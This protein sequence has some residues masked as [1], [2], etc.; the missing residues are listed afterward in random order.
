M[1]NIKLNS[2]VS[3]DNKYGI[4]KVVDIDDEKY[5]VS[6]FIDI[7]TQVKQNFNITELE[8]VYLSPQTRVYLKDDSGQWKI[9][10][11]KD[12]DN[13]T[14]PEMDYL[15][16]FP[17]HKE[18]WYAS[19]EL[20]VRCLL[21]TIDPTEVLST[22]G[23]ESQFLYDSRKNVQK[24][25]I[26]LRA[27]SRGITALTSASIDLVVHQVNI[28]RKILTDPIQRYLLSD[29]VGMG[30]TIEAGII[31][32]Q[33]LL[34][35]QYSKVLIIVPSH[36]LSKWKREMKER[37][38]FD[39]FEDRFEIT[40][41]EN[42]GVNIT[43]P[44]LVIVDEAHHLLGNLNT[45]SESIRNNIITIATKSAKLLLLSATPGIGNE[46]V[47][48]NLLKVLDPVVFG[49]ESLDVFKEK[50]LKQTEHG[51]F[52]RTLKV[53][54]STFLLKRNLPKIED[55]FPG[56]NQ[57]KILKDKI[58]DIID[59]EYKEE[60]RH[61]LIKQLRI[62]L[63]ETWRLHNRLIRTRRVD[64]EGWEFQE[65]GKKENNSYV[66]DNIHSFEHPNKIVEQINSQ[67]EEW[68]SYLSLK[69]LDDDK[70]LSLA[71]ERYIALL[72]TSNM[73]FD[74]FKK[75]IDEYINTPLV[76]EELEYLRNILISIDD[77]NYA[78]N[79]SKIC[80]EIQ[81]FLNNINNSSIGVL[82]IS[83]AILAKRYALSLQS[84]FDEESVCLLQSVTTDSSE[85]SDSKLRIIVCDRNS[86][87]GVD[88]QF[89]DAIIHLDLPLNPSRVEQ[90]IGRLDRYGRTKSLKIQHLIMIPTNDESYP[91]LAWYKLLLNG[92]NIFHEPIS[93]IQLKL[94]S[95]T[96][97]LQTMLFAHGTLGLESNFD[98][99]ENITGSLIDKI[100]SVI[101]IER[102]ALDEQYALNHLSLM[103]SESFNI[104]DEIEEVEYDERSLEEDMNHWLFSVLQFYKWNIND[105]IFEIKWHPKTLI[106]K[107]Q[108]W[109]NNTLVS[110]SM[111]EGEFESSLDR[112]LTYY[113]KDAV[114]NKE[115]SLLRPGHPLFTTL[116]HYMDWEDRGTAFSTFRVVDEKFPIF[117]PRN[118]IKI[119]FKLHFIVEAGF[120]TD[121][122]EQE[123]NSE[124]FLY[125]RRVDDYHPPKI[126]TVY[127]DENLNVIDDIDITDVLDEPY[128]DL[129]NIDTNL[130][131]RRN[132]IDYF[133]DS[134]ILDQLCLDVSTRSKEILL[135]SSEYTSFNTEAVEKARMDIGLKCVSLEHR[136][137][138]QAQLNNQ[139]MSEEYD[140]TIQ[141]E[142]SLM[143]GITNP[144]IK[145]DSFGMY[146]LSRFP[147]SELNIDD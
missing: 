137:N 109:S 20:E 120:A 142:E 10:R 145:L 53:N 147:L 13:T 9:G 96:S 129:Q 91:W 27:S 144:K 78:D 108:F 16:S 46:D 97:K 35:S 51:A 32:R 131:S 34:D 82:F 132:V 127:I 101:H 92:F 68:R 14:N 48:L 45:Y 28:V 33:C 90:R 38:Y 63:V 42:I 118:D 128:L 5:Q 110:T 105:K 65:R 43:N 29:E 30:K 3:I 54:Q 18:D 4:G 57:A 36:L 25:L 19:E 47:L 122:L 39:D 70:S 94:E 106:P 103:E 88:L 74:V 111:W 143:Q 140:K 107:Q 15:I 23:G 117:I 75:K 104:R 79:I 66:M 84:I 100:S 126:F 50:V 73:D 116:Q 115:V 24:W 55:I 134:D 80:L 114:E 61:F 64:S 124:H 6:F 130:S 40:S 22:S 95:I 71:K 77:Y 21:P 69:F 85:L 99:N 44:E 119:M 86:E 58:L 139:H 37:F 56:D 62:H 52:L 59:D 31:A 112:H 17:N 133:I 76:K 12:F 83:D 67:I 26:D 72:E 1:P 135:N 8:L 81:Q 87:E 60:K 98:E 113:R 49:N 7:K 93:D 11:V 146:F 41:P 2:L 141:F 123:Y 138:I 89:A 102:E 125:L 121:K 136:K